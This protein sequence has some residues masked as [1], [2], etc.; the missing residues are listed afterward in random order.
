MI[1]GLALISFAIQ[2]FL[3]RWIFRVDEKV[4]N[5]KATIWLLMKIA[6]KQGV[7]PEDIQAIKTSFNIK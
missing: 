7:T 5:Q 3:L 2:F 1:A 4:S 6:E